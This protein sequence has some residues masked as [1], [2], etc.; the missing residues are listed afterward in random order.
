MKTVLEVYQEVMKSAQYMREN[1]TGEIGQAVAQNLYWVAGLL[2]Q[3]EEVN[4]THK[5]KGVPEKLQ[6]FFK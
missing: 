2:E 5:V 3:T 1:S 6:H 4:P